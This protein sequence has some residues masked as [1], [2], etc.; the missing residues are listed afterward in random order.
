V[1]SS[2]SVRQLSRCA[3]A[4]TGSGRVFPGVEI[5]VADMRPFIDMVLPPSAS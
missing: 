1:P 5:P 4:K 3:F 2:S